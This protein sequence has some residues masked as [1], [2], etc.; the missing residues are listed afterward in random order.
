M[1]SANKLLRNALMVAATTLAV[2]S[3]AASATNV[4]DQ[5]VTDDVK[6]MISKVG[7]RAPADLNF[8]VTNGVVNFTGWA[9]YPG[10]VR[11]AVIAALRVEGVH[12]AY[13]NMVR[14]WSQ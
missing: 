9:R 14:T 6:E 11:N 5:K 13:G 4:S 8:S 3:G 2:F 7:L 1:T 12:T 10:E